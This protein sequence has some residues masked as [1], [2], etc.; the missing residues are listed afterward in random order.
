[1]H[2]KNQLKIFIKMGTE[3]IDLRCLHRIMLGEIHLQLV[4]FASV[5]RACCPRYIDDPP[6]FVVSS[7]IIFAFL[8]IFFLPGSQKHLKD[9]NV[10]KLKPPWKRR[11]EN[12]KETNVYKPKT[13]ATYHVASRRV[14]GAGRARLA[15]KKTVAKHGATEKGI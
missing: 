2:T 7:T 1:M 10:Y 12:N 8:K 3:D 6:F 5:E 9:S 11:R 15:N 14:Q 13:H 4:G